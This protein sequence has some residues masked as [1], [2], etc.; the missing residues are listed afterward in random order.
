MWCLPL[1]AV[2]VLGNSIALSVRGYIH[3]AVPQ[4]AKKVGQLHQNGNNPIPIYL[5]CAT[6]PT[7]CNKNCIF[8]M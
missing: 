4:S 2:K 8:N 7:L 1:K 6:K 5:H 3:C